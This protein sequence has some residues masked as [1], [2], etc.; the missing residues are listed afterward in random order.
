[1]EQGTK[2]SATTILDFACDFLIPVYRFCMKPANGVRYLRWGGD[3]EAVQPEKA[4]GAG[5]CLKMAQN[6]Q[7]QVHALLACS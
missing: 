5:N 4:S 2:I 6:P 3:G 1:M 7:R